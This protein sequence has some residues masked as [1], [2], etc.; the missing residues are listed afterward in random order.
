MQRLLQLMK[1]AG[2]PRR[3][4]SIRVFAV[5]IALGLFAF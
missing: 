4:V 1:Q 5:T 2:Q 3:S